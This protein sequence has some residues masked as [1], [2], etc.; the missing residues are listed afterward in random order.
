MRTKEKMASASAQ[1]I[2]Q[3]ERGVLTLDF[4][5]ALVIAFGFTTVF[6]ALALTLSMVEV[7]QYISFAT[8][9]CYVGAHETIGAQ[10]ALAQNKYKELMAVPVFKTLF[11]TGWF[12]LGSPTV[13]DF[14]SEY[15]QA[16]TGVDSATFSGARIKF[17]PNV[18]NVTLP[19]LGS[20]GADSNTGVANI[21][22]YLMR[23]V[24]TTECRE[25][26]DRNRFVKLKALAAEYKG[27][28]AQSSPVMPDNGC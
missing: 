11:A 16:N 13:G 8:A 25:D 23:E 3:N 22:T 17:T 20:T 19:F 28:P 1:N 12:K 26:F 7:T 15:P 6:F 14:N 10:Q 21:S 9:R 18:L 4:I 5:F 24:S 27:A 2:L